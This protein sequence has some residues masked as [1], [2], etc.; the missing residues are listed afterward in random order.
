MMKITRRRAL[1]MFSATLGMGFGTG[2]LF[3][4]GKSNRALNGHILGNT[5]AIH[6]PAIAA[7]NEGLPALGYAPPKLA[8]IDSMQVLTQSIIGKSAELGEA[9]ISSS[10]QASFAGADLKLIGLVYANASLVFVANSDVIKDFAD[11]LKPGVV[12]AVNSK[13][14]WIHAMLSG[15]LSKRG[16]DPSKATVVEIGGSASRVQALLANRVQVVP[17]HFDQTPDILSK[18]NYKIMLKPWE[19]YKLFIA[20]CWLASGEWLKNPDNQR[21][22]VDIQKATITSFRKANRDLSYFG[23]AYRK[24]STIKGASALTDEQLKPVWETMSKTARAWP[25]D[26]MFK[27][28]Y[29]RDLLPVYKAVGSFP[30]EPDLGR[31]IDTSYTEQALKELG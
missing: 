23:N 29:F 8:R 31:L 21:L 27:R 3:A 19:E 25:D 7:L 9:D 13:G 6:I 24:F 16:L 26:G 30:R 28:E 5:L 2:P 12:V 1:G 22:A 17:V 18:G 4:Q 10:L 15:A 11:F 20:E 14:D